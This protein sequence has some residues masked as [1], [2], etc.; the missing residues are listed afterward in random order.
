[1]WVQHFLGYT[2]RALTKTELGII[3]A[4]K[5]DQ[6]DIESRTFTRFMPTHPNH[7]CA[8]WARE[9]MDN[10]EWLFSY[11]IAL[12]EEYTFRYDKSHKSV[13]AGIAN[14]EPSG[15]PYK[16]LT[17]RPQCMPDDY[18]DDDV[19]AAYRMYYMMDKSP[20]AKWK[21]RDVPTWWDEYLINEKG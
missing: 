10:Y 17:T 14:P 2:P 20:F 1:V 13:K 6:P 21:N 11:L 19:V 9:S 4:V 18:K 5:A 7:P 3:N 16:G 15:L 12:G 8:I